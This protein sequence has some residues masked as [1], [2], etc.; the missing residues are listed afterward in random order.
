MSVYFKF[1]NSVDH[2]I[3]HFDGVNISVPDFK[4]AM[5]QQKRLSSADCDYQITDAKTKE[6]QFPFC[7]V[8][9]LTHPFPVSTTHSPSL[10]ERQVHFKEHVSSGGTHTTGAEAA[11]QL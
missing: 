11:T 4:K 6:G 10:R 3:V 5:M 2:D 8:S 7:P 9:P 1:R